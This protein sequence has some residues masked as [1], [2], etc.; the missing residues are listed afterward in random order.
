MTVR[1]LAFGLFVLM[2]A[3]CTGREG[4]REKWA[5]LTPEISREALIDTEDSLSAPVDADYL[6]RDSEGRV[7]LFDRTSLSILAYTR[8]G[9]EIRSLGG[10]GRG[11]GEFAGGNGMAVRRDTLY[12]FDRNLSR[13]NLF[14]TSG[15]FLRARTL[16]GFASSV[17]MIPLG[18]GW[19]VMGIHSST[20]DMTEGLDLAKNPMAHTFSPDFRGPGTSF[21]RADEVDEG[22]QDITGLIGSSRGEVAVL[23]GDRFIFSPEI[24]SGRIYEYRRNEAGEWRQEEVHNGNIYAAPF[25]LL[26]ENDS[27]EAELTFHDSSTG[28]SM[29]LVVNNRSLGLHRAGEYIFHFTSVK[30]EGESVFGAELYDREMNALGYI[31][32]ASAPFD[33]FLERLTLSMT[34][35]SDSDGKGNFYLL[36][37]VAESA[38]VDLLQVDLSALPK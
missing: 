19:L 23:G 7:Y 36:N 18:A 33:N 9:K 5:R 24:Y 30:R 16:K 10:E 20:L 21:L 27:R 15:E 4:E 1:L 37:T 38:K 6:Q 32:I 31:S 26:E 34:T 8:E 11:P 25:E 2:L 29:R 12:L 17:K 35:V 28:E 13:L 3:G 22:L 14:D